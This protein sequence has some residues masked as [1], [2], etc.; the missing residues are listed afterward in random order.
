MSTRS[1]AISLYK[2]ILRAHK[3]FLPHEMRQL[4]DAYVKAE[5]RTTVF[6]PFLLCCYDIMKQ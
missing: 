6:T 5:V 2:N 4:G 1:Q 3:R